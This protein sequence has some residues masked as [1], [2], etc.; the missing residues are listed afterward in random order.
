MK[1][2]PGFS[3]A[4]A[5]YPLLTSSPGH[6]QLQFTNSKG[7]PV[8]VLFEGVPAFRWQ[9]GELPLEPGEPYDGAFELKGSAWLSQHAEGNTMHSGPGL[10]HLRFNF[11][12]WG[13][14]EVLCSSFTVRA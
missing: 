13:C 8:S 6:L 5:G 4:D 3:T 12:A 7:Q 2:S 14:L 1:L 11:N 10:R 9:E